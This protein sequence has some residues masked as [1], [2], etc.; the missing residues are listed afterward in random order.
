[1]SSSATP[2]PDRDAQLLD[3][4]HQCSLETCLLH[5]FLPFK[6]QHCNEPFCSDHYLPDAHK[7]PKYD[8][9]KHNRIAPN[10][11]CTCATVVPCSVD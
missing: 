7:C 1:M 11:K 3:I 2:T 9:T 6:C 10:C 4:G 8:E 5:D